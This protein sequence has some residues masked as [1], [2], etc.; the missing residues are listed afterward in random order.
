MKVIK[1]AGPSLVC[2]TLGLGLCA[3]AFHGCAQTDGGGGNTPGAGG[4]SSTGGTG[5]RGGSGGSSAT[6]GAGPG[7]GGAS[8]S[9]GSSA[10][11]GSGGSSATGGS[12]TAG[13]GG[14][15]A[16]TGGGGMAGAGGA[17]SGGAAGGGMVPAA[18]ARPFPAHTTY[19]PGVLKPTIAQATMDQ[20]VRSFYTKWK[21]IHVK[22]ACGGRYVHTGGG[23]GVPEGVSAITISEGHGYG[24]LAVAYMAGADPQAQ[25][26]F[27]GMHTFA[28]KFPS[29]NQNGLMAW[30]ILAS[31]MLPS[32][33]TGDMTPDSAAD[34]DLDMAYAYLIAHHQWGSNGA[35]NYFEE[36]RKLIAAIKQHEVNPETNLIMLGDWADI[37]ASYYNARYAMGGHTGPYERGSHADF[38]YGTRPSDFMLDHIRAFAAA[39]GDTAWGDKVVGSHYQLI[40]HIQTNFSARTGLLPDFIEKTKVLAQAAPAQPKYLEWEDDG[41]FA[42]NACRVPWRLGTDFVVSGDPRAR[43]ALQKMNSWI[44]TAT[45]KNPAMIKNGYRLDGTPLEAVGSYLFS[46]PFGVA[47]M[48]DDSADGQA[49]LDAVWRHVANDNSEGY[50]PD[51]IKLFSMLVMSGNWWAP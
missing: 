33:V 36:A 51:S 32:E 48:A 7:S 2:V 14:G 39:I 17:G 12:G 43:T 13:T 4:S 10:T 5:G 38:Y 9:G 20:A 29:I 22:E 28:K 26:T 35:V 46:A 49:W 1:I 11:G 50:Y 8:G 40:N 31:C 3:L 19:K 44:K 23:T 30:V 18:M 34:G 24:M 16:G 21:M 27:D 47:A 37:K 15:G 45:G 6:G 42:P 25:Q 41:N